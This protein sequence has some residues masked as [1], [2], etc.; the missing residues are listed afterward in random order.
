MWEMNC[1]GAMTVF[2]NYL[3]YCLRQAIISVSRNRW[4]ALVSAA[5]IAVALAILGGFLLAAANINQVMKNVQS[6]LEIAVFLDTTA[7]IPEL[8]D[9]IEQLEGVTSLNFVDKHA[10]LQEFGRSLGDEAL[11]EELTG[12]NNPLPH[13]FL[14]RG[15]SAGLIPGLAGQIEGFS[16]VESVDYG[17]ELVQNITRISGWLNSISIAISV[18]LA[19]GAIFLVGTTVRLS[20]AIRREEIEIMKHLGAGNRFIRLPFLLEGLAIGFTGTLA[21]LTA[22][23]LA[24][25]RFALFLIQSS[26]L[27]FLHPVTAPV[28]LILIFGGL[29][30]LGIAMGGLGGIYS[31]RRFSGV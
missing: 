15:G 4:P 1:K 22:L 13:A 2:I 28:K 19:V 7:D 12:E 21:A 26:P 27:F 16:G 6:N 29:L 9:K 11:L 3:G 31:I 14:V 17:G 10:G 30:L 18:L 24:Y 25:H 23:G 5:M 20:V 8:E